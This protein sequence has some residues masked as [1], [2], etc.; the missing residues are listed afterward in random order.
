MPH[1]E[2]ELAQPLD[3]VFQPP[4]SGDGAVDHAEEVHLGDVGEA[5]SGIGSLLVGVR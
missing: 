4:H 1:V 3:G 2:A 5:A